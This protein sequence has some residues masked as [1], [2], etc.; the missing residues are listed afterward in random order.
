MINLSPQVQM[1][2]NFHLSQDPNYL[3]TALCTALQNTFDA[4]HTEKHED[5]SKPM[6]NTYSYL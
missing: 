2:I 3:T 1:T 4:Q 5:D 6:L